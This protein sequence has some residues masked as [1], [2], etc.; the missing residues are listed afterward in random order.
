MQLHLPNFEFLFSKLE[1]WKD[2]KKSTKRELLS[3][4]EKLSFASKII[5]AGC[6]FIRRL[7]N[8]STTVKKLNQ[9]I[10]LN[11]ETKNAV[12]WWLD[13]LPTRNGKYTILNHHTSL[14]FDL[15]LYT[16][17]YGSLGFGN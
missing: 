3:I 16:D 2:K 14:T 11:T 9:H 7:I 4:I 13:F 1:R 10:S 5:P 8:L 12:K 15:Q 17:A 6:T